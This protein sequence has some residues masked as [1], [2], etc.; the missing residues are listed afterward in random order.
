MKKTQPRPVA[1]HVGPRKPPNPKRKRLQETLRNAM[2]IGGSMALAHATISALG[3]QLEAEGVSPDRYFD[4]TVT[5]P[6]EVRRRIKAIHDIHK[7]CRSYYTLT[8]A[9]TLRVAAYKG[10]KLFDTVA[11]ITFNAG[12]RTPGF[13]ARELKYMKDNSIRTFKNIND[14]TNTTYKAYSSVRR[15]MEQTGIGKMAQVNA[16]LVNKANTQVNTQANTKANT[17]VNTQA[18]TKANTQAKAKNISQTKTQDT[19]N[20]NTG[21]QENTNTGTQENTNTGPNKENQEKGWSTN[22]KIA[23]AG[24]ALVAAVGIGLLA[25]DLSKVALEYVPEIP[26]IWDAIT[27]RSGAH[28]FMERA[29]EVYHPVHQIAKEKFF[30]T[31]IER[32]AIMEAA[33][34]T[35]QVMKA[36]STASA[37]FGTYMG[38]SAFKNSK[39]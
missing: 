35:G 9:Q 38:W 19:G 1:Y 22:A 29:G 36:A 28:V 39:K 6:L 30:D 2:L 24:V 8:P 12:L 10:V 31:I 21:T 33:K 23:T 37:G 5:H 34:Y 7:A 18:N 14:F 16:N 20:T 11:N 4:N 13:I 15:T 26:P 32:G 17:Q 25:P 3:T 27:L